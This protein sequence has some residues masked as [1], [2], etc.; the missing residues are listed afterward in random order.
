MFLHEAATGLLWPG[1]ILD[2]CV[3]DEVRFPQIRIQ[4]VKTNTP[5]DVASPQ[6]DL[7]M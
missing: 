1:F 7:I 6:T 3:N 5:K 2:V 4:T